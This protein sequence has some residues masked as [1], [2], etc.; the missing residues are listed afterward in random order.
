MVSTPSRRPPARRDTSASTTSISS[1]KSLVR[2]PSSV[3]TVP[4]SGARRTNSTA[5]FSS[6]NGTLDPSSIQSYESVFEHYQPPQVRVVA[7]QLRKEAQTK[8][9]QLRELVGESY[10]DLLATA[11][12]IID[13]NG[14]VSS[15]E[16][17]F[18][19]LGRGCK[20]SALR[21]R[22]RNLESVVDRFAETDLDRKR[23][24]ALSKNIQ[25]FFFA[26]EYLLRNPTFILTSCKVL[27]AVK[28]LLAVIDVHESFLHARF[29]ALEARFLSC[30]D[31]ILKGAVTA[32]ILD[33][34]VSY[35]LYSSSN[36][37]DTISYFLGVRIA[38][39]KSLM[40]DGTPESLIDALAVFDS[41]IST[42]KTL[43]PNQFQRSLSRAAVLPVLQD[44]EI[45]KLPY[46]DFS[47]LDVW[48]PKSISEHILVLS[49]DEKALNTNESLKSFEKTVVNSFEEGVRLVIE[50]VVAAVEPGKVTAGS[51]EA[52]QSLLDL[53][54]KIFESLV[55]RP[56]I[57]AV[58]ISDS[59]TWEKEWLPALKKLCLT[60]L[61]AAESIAA[62]L[63]DA[64]SDVN[65]GKSTES[66]IMSLW[67]DRWMDLD[68]SRGAL[69][70]RSA[71]S[72]LLSG[73]AS[74]CGIIIDEIRSWWSAVKDVH[75]TVSKV[76]GVFDYNSYGDEEEEWVKS[77]R[78]LA[79]GEAKALE[80]V[81]DNDV[82]PG[83]V[84]TLLAKIDDMLKETAGDKQKLGSLVRVTRRIGELPLSSEVKDEVSSTVIRVY[85]AFAHAL[86]DK[87]VSPAQVRKFLESLPASELWE[88]EPQTIPSAVHTKYP[89]D[90]SPWLSEGVY[91]T[92]VEP[93]ISGG[94]EDVVIGSSVSV[95][96]FRIVA[97]S[98]WAKAISA[99]IQEHFESLKKV[100]TNGDGVVKQGESEISAVSENQN[101]EPESSPGATAETSAGTTPDDKDTGSEEQS[102]KDNAAKEGEDSNEEKSDSSEETQEPEPE[103]S[104]E[105]ENSDEKKSPENS[106]QTSTE[107]ETETKIE[108]PEEESQESK[109]EIFPTKDNWTQLLFD[110]LYLENVF[111][112]RLQK[113]LD[114][115]VEELDK[116]MEQGERKKLESVVQ[117]RVEACWK[118]TYLLY[119]IM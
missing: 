104:E 87:D 18:K 115:V 23:R 36:S 44:S 38:Q 2:S 89:T 72:A 28:E 25:D 27:L 78:D 54:R 101:P 13:M 14:T 80:L 117:K 53:R 76:S 97:G 96:V 62:Q 111:N 3:P 68:I 110:V 99:G 30:L 108:K 7:F 67:D 60:Y 61:G 86:F 55:D 109:S 74:S 46:I 16:D 59:S 73:K 113:T 33:G 58:L 94:W 112:M 93:I 17:Q 57:R 90:V 106:E 70:F 15:L 49:K 71:V 75:T 65:S 8:R 95:V 1:L 105:A 48:V 4:I 5:S 41:T 37:G 92:Y 63:A 85:E 52:I 31:K 56:A 81:I 84:K 20:S 45:R 64:V 10:R 107:T 39:I 42:S 51:K 77:V 50:S 118:R 43:F 47:V 91:S 102:T 114:V 21:H 9:E 66:G 116:L 98:K 103:K 34:L 11:D 119:A 82:I 88:E 19:Q 29:K 40:E 26:L 69:D 100:D 79:L 6:I 12:M 83:G 32:V 22:A 24:V 35:S